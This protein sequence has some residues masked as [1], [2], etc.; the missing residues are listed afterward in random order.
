MA[1]GKFVLSKGKTGTFRFNLYSTNG[2]I[3][4]TSEA[5]ESKTAALGGVA[6]V[7]KLAAGA[8]LVDETNST[9]PAK[10]SSAT[11][12]TKTSA[13]KRTAKKTTAASG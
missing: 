3:V 8:R 10:K 7:Q 12:T 2:R 4:A 6:A 13:T 5:Y 9:A 1:T 11:K